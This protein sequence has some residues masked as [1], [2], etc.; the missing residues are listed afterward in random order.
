VQQR[1]RSSPRLRHESGVSRCNGPPTIRRDTFRLQVFAFT[2]YIYSHAIGTIRQILGLKREL[3]F[4]QVE[5]Q[6]DGFYRSYRGGAAPGV[7]V[8]LDWRW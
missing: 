6:L 5:D 1:L 4:D 3:W 2:E 8:Q 7:N